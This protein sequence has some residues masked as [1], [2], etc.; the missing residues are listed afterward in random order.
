MPDSPPV[1]N[2]TTASDD[3]LAHGVIS[4]ANLLNS[5]AQSTDIDIDQDLHNSKRSAETSNSELPV[6]LPVR[7]SANNS[8]DGF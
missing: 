5:S 4:D 3:E 2:P 8:P 1:I 7:K 6:L